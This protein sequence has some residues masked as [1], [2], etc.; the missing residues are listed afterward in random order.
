MALAKPLLAMFN[1]ELAVQPAQAAPGTN[2]MF[3]EFQPS[4]SDSDSS[5]LAGSGPDKKQE[6]KRTKL[7]STVAKSAVASAARPLV[8][9]ASSTAQALAVELVPQPDHGGAQPR[10]RGR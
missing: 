7:G 8:P 1:P 6:R 5:G 4:S 3:V 10:S 2:D 9:G